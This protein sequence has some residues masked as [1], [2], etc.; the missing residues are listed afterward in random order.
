MELILAAVTALVIY[1][2]W[3]RRRHPKKVCGRC[4]GT[5]QKTSSW[6]GRAF[7]VCRRC[8]GKGEVRR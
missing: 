7:G 1:Y 5:G 8:R 4:G 6:N 2:M 3:D